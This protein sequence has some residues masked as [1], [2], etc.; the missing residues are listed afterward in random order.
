MEQLLLP[1]F[2][3]IVEGVVNRI[4]FTYLPNNCIFSLRQGF[5]L[6]LESSISSLQSPPSL[7]VS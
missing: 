7:T 3:M 2:E 6:S 5:S 1:K 4:L